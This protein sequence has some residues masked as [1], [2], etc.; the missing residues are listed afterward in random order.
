MRELDD[1]EGQRLLR[2]IRLD[3]DTRNGVIGRPFLRTA[4]KGKAVSDSP[5][6]TFAPVP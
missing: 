3:R 6:R 1:D 4:E 2:I 5:T